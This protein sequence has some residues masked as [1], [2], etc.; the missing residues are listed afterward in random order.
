MDESGASIPGLTGELQYRRRPDGW[1][2]DD[3]FTLFQLI[4]SRRQRAYQIEV[5][6]E[7]KISHVENGVPWFGPH[8]HF[9]DKAVQFG[10]VHLPPNADHQAWF[11]EF[12]GR[13]NITF[14]GEYRH[15]DPQGSLFP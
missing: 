12:V 11:W 9:G 3:R 1:E 5:K 15:P 8:E 14:E 6:P 13:A 7:D 4:R 10:A 2:C